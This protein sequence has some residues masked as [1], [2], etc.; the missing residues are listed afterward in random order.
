MKACLS[1]GFNLIRSKVMRGS[2][3]GA[4]GTSGAV[5]RAPISVSWY[6]VKAVRHLG[7]RAWDTV[8]GAVAVAVPVFPGWASPR[9]FSQRM[10]AS[11]DQRISYYST[12]NSPKQRKTLSLLLSDLCFTRQL[13][14]KIVLK[15]SSNKGNKQV[16]CRQR[17]YGDRVRPFQVRSCIISLLPYSSCR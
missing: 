15:Q 2:R 4:A 12:G 14:T 17:C 8:S 5:R 16:L 10:S 3:A 11:P 7:C 9:L 13:T 6:P 1:A